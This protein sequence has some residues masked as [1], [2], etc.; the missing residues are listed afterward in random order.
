MVKILS[1]V[2]GTTCSFLPLPVQISQLFIS[3]KRQQQMQFSNSSPTHQ[4]RQ[5]NIKAIRRLGDRMVRPCGQPHTRMVN[6]LSMPVT[7]SKGPGDGHPTLD[8][9]ITRSHSKKNTGYSGGAHCRNGGTGGWERNEMLSR[10]LVYPSNGD[11][12]SA[13]HAQSFPPSPSLQAG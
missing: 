8:L 9:N 4:A 12:T 10:A 13:L 7:T 6:P 1:S 11:K 5:G 2:A 3:E